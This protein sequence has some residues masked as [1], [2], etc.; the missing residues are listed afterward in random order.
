MQ[1]TPSVL[2]V[3]PP[4]L[5]CDRT[6]VRFLRRPQLLNRVSSPRRQEE[7]LPRPC[8]FCAFSVPLSPHRRQAIPCVTAAHVRVCRVMRLC[9]AAGS[10]LHVFAGGSIHGDTGFY[11]T[12]C[13]AFAPSY[14]AAGWPG[15]WRDVLRLAPAWPHHAVGRRSGTTQA[16][17]HPARARV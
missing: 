14:A 8:P 9:R 2:S 11:A 4:V 16:R 6:H 15:G 5:L 3:A 12:I 7:P 13:T 10:R 1:P 17:R